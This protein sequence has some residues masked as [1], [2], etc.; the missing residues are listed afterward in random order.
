MRTTTHAHL[1]TWHVLYYMTLYNRDWLSNRLTPHTVLSTHGDCERDLYETKTGCLI[2]QS[3][4]SD[5]FSQLLIF[6]S[7]FC[8]VLQNCEFISLDSDFFLTIQI[9]FPLRIVKYKLIIER[10]YFSSESD[11]VTHKLKVHTRITR[12]KS[13]SRDKFAIARKKKVRITILVLSQFLINLR[14]YGTTHLIDDP[15]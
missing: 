9:F 2:Y 13:E 5:F 7:Q 6:I 3:I 15:S 12:I 8:L 1:E 14:N 10:K 11:F 4:H